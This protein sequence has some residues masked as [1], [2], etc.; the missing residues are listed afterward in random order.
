MINHMT[1]TTGLVIF[2]LCLLFR[3]FRVLMSV[4]LGWIFTVIGSIGLVVMMVGSFLVGI[5][6][7]VGNF[8]RQGH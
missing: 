1:L 7:A 5:I 8:L 2:Y 6:I 3:P 4:I